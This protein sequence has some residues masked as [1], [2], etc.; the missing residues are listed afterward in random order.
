MVDDEYTPRKTVQEVKRFLEQGID[1]LL[2]PMGST[3]LAAYLDLVK[4]GKVLV[5]FPMTGAS[6]FRKKDLK[7]IAHI[8][9]SYTIEGKIL[10]E[11]ALDTLKA[12]RAVMFYQ[13]DEFGQGFMDGAQK[14]LKKRGIIDW[15]AV[16]YQR[17]DVNFSKQ[18]AEINKYDPD[19]LVFFATATAA[20][21]L[22]R[23]MG[24]Q[25][26]S[27]KQ[28]IA[29][30]DVGDEKF[31]KFIKEKGLKIIYINV[32]PNPHQSDIAIVKQF[33]DAATREGVLIDVFGLE[34]YIATDFLLDILSKIKG[35]V[36]KEKLIDAI[37][38]VKNYNHKGFMF[39]F[40]PENRTLSSRLWMYTGSPDCQQI[41][42][43]PDKE[44][45]Q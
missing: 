39:N 24:I 28:M 44:D 40:D 27:A 6:L 38:K 21:G 2:T 8:R 45:M 9:P 14:V 20:K 32:V 25:E 3:T 5:L 29:A 26:V 31:L 16:P 37:E 17:N 42:I 35:E 36:T 41:E 23:Q 19:T 18:I 22:I 10:T 15:L 7:Y 1:I 43:K 33:R 4:E 30:S 11:Y 13:N 34:S 12:K